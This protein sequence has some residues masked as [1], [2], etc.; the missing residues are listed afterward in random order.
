MWWAHLCPNHIQLDEQTTSEYVA[1]KNEVAGRVVSTGI[2]SN[3]I[4]IFFGQL[5]GRNADPSGRAV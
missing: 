5:Y 4:N 2:E 1:F 3:L